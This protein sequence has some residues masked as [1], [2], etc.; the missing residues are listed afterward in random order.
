MYSR[1]NGSVKR[2]LQV[3]GKFN[4]K[5]LGAR[6]ITISTVIVLV[7]MF[8]LASVVTMNLDIVNSWA[9]FWQNI[10]GQ[11]WNLII[12]LIGGKSATSIPYEGWLSLGIVKVAFKTIISTLSILVTGITVAAITSYM[13]EKILRRLMGMS[14]PVLVKHTLVCG[15]NQSAEL[16]V[17]RIHDE[18]ED[19]PVVL[20]CDRD[21]APIT[22]KNLF[23]VR[24]DHTK[25]GILEKAH[26][27]KANTAIILSDLESAGNSKELADART[28]LSVLTIESLHP[29]IHTAAELLDPSNENHLRRANVDEIVISG[30]LSGTILSRVSE[31]KGLSR[32]VKSLLTVGEGSEIY[33]LTN[34]PDNINTSLF[35]DL[36]LRL[37]KEKGYILLGFEDANCDICISPP[38]DAKLNDAE[39]LYIISEDKPVLT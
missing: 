14:L 16:I 24:G 9:S 39:A 5:L 4:K 21:K 6:T 20:V 10:L 26:V 3:L 25:V 12:Y 32:V 33:R 13:V 28:V 29:D 11:F 7:S 35:G 36:H 23:W 2:I 27:K 8:V 17:K 38:L 22:G 18:D 37:Y 15:W 1:Q 19:E 31:N 30:E 34:L